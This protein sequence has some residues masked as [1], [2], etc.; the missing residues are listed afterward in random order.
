MK[1]CFL[2]V[3]FSAASFFGWSQA[4][5]KF[6][7]P[8]TYWDCSWVYTGFPAGCANTVNRIFFPGPDTVLEGVTYKI[9]YAYPM[10][11]DPPNGFNCPPY[12]VSN[13]AANYH[14]YIREDTVARKVYIYYPVFILQAPDQLL[15]DFSLKP[16]DS[17]LSAF[18]GNWAVTSV[19]SVM[20]ST[21]EYRRRT[22]FMVPTLGYGYYIEGIGGQQGLFTPIFTFEQAG[23]MLCVKENN[24]SLWGNYCNSWFVDVPEHRMIVS[25]IYPNPSTN[26]CIVSWKDPS[27]GE[28]VIS[29]TD[30]NGI[31]VLNKSIH[32]HSSVEM[33]VSAL[34]KGIYLVKITTSSGVEKRKLLIR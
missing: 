3:L 7:R 21:G 26:T 24:V 9:A 12:S 23:S 16:G 25:E 30:M 14:Q 18:Q 31:Q 11:A 19:D 20:L 1:K 17:L 32:G 6:I 2:L 22:N 29:L 28:I 33:D 13:T 10:Q 15:Y 27:N 8:N 5:H 4:Y 34:T